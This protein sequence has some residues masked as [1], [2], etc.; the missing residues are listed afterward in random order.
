MNEKITIDGVSRV[1]DIGKGKTVVAVDDVAGGMV[2]VVG[3]SWW[4]SI[5]ASWVWGGTERNSLFGRRSPKIVA[6][7]L[8]GRNACFLVV[9]VVVVAAAVV[10]SN[11]D[12]QTIQ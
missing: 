11:C 8:G 5:V 7:A 9:V 4:K 12:C 3:W 1:Y 6:S 2:M 10:G